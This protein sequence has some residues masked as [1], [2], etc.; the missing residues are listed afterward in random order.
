MV[1]YCSFDS[2]WVNLI[3]SCDRTYYYALTSSGGG[4]LFVSSSGF[5][6]LHAAVQCE[7]VVAS[8][9][10][11]TVTKNGLEYLDTIEYECVEGHYF[12]DNTTVH[13]SGCDAA[14]EWNITD[15][16]NC[17]RKLI[18]LSESVPQLSPRNSHLVSV[19]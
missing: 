2:Q 10:N 8:N 13:I 3:G 11:L 6:F 4:W 12:S 15:D 19:L 1:A 9:A 16:Q 5:S 7:D 14:A 18:A 17:G